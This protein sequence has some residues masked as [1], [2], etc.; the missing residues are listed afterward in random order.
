MKKLIILTLCFALLLCSCGGEDRTE[1]TEAPK[2]DWRNTVTYDG[3]T[4]LNKDT[5][6]L[7]L[8]DKGEITIWDN[9]GDGTP[10][11]TLS[12]E[13]YYDKAYDT[14][15]FTDIN[16]D[17]SKDLLVAYNL[18]EGVELYN[19]WLW[20]A[21]SGS[22]TAIP[23]Y[24]TI[25]SPTV[26][27][28]GT[29]VSGKRDLGIFG[30]LEMTYTFGADLSFTKTGLDITNAPEISKA[31]ADAFAQCDEVAR[32]EGTVTLDGEE[33]TVYRALDSHGEVAYTAYTPEGEW[34]IDVGCVGAYRAVKDSG[35]SYALSHYS[36]DAGEAYDICSS[37]TK[38]ESAHIT[39]VT[40]GSVS[41]S[42]GTAYTF[43]LE[44]GESCT[45]IKTESGIWYG[46]YGKLDE[47]KIISASGETVL[48]EGETYTFTSIYE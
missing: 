9:A 16:K 29:T 24:K 32:A 33:C 27:E 5:K 2:T 3:S 42:D 41:D 21:E 34:Y 17:G 40:K 45:V 13:T 46:T 4:Y 36:D 12:Y 38:S 47:C 28:D 1:T 48:V 37:L 23:L 22:F 19:L 20:N 25:Y 6:I 8:L 39:R 30:I 44:G 18:K 11:Q 43:T 35:G 10:L 26:S 14:V 15:E 31:I 7:Y